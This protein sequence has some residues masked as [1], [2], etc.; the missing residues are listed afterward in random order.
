MRERGREGGRDRQ[1]H[2]RS[3]RDVALI[4]LNRSAITQPASCLLIAGFTA[5]RVCSSL[6]LPVLLPPPPSGPLSPSLSSSLLL[7]V[8]LS[9]HACLPGTASTRQSLSQPS[10]ESP[11]Q[12]FRGKRMLSLIFLPA[13][14]A[15]R[16]MGIR[17]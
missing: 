6:P 15:L 3:E 13:T 2:G 12:S 9:P 16:A 4:W 14:A 7:P 1:T 17:K 10:G 8:L 11:R 5:S